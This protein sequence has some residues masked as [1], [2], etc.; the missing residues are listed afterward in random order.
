MILAEL[1]KYFGDDVKITTL[2]CKQV[3]VDTLSLP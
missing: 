1:V 3:H 2:V